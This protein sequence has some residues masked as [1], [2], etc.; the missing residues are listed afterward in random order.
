[1]SD[2]HNFYQQVADECCRRDF[3]SELSNT[4]EGL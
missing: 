4:Q 1:M 2:K 3:I